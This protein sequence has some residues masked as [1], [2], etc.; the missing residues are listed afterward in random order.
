MG[1]KKLGHAEMKTNG[2]LFYFFQHVKFSQH[3]PHTIRPLHISGE[4]CKGE[5]RLEEEDLGGRT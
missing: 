5:R 2:F 1:V 4:M 3:S